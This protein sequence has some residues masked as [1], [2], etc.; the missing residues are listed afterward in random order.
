MPSITLIIRD[1]L[2]LAVHNGGA[3]GKIGSGSTISTSMAGTLGAAVS[4][5][6]LEPEEN[7]SNQ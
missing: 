2:R 5:D 3:L 6:S 1:D 7:S 4:S